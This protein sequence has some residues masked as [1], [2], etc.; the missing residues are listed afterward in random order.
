MIAPDEEV[1]RVVEPAREHVGVE[2]QHLLVQFGAPVRAGDLVDRRLDADLRQAFLHQDAERLV[3]GREA[4]IERQRGLEAVRDNRPRRVAALPWRCRCCSRAVAARRLRSACRP[5]AEHR[6]AETVKH[7][8][9]DLLVR[10]CVGHRLPD[11]RIVERRLGDVHAEILD[12][13]RERRRDDVELAGILQLD[14]ILVRQF[15]GDVGVAALKQR[16][17]VAGRGHH[18]PDDALHLRHAPRRPTCRCARGRPR[19]PRVHC[20]TR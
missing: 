10:D 9:H 5:R 6:L 15:V 11:F 17:A 14:E 20:T 2:R 16:A 8:I 1:L 19:C 13:V 18:A 3:D 12:A 4:Q 7:R